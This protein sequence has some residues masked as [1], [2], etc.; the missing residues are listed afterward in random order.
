MQKK[1][2]TIIMALLLHAC[3]FAQPDDCKYDKNE[4]DKFTNQKIVWTKWERLAPL[5][6][7]EYAPD[8][9]CIIQDSIKQLIVSV[10]EYSTTYDKPT[11]GYL[12]SFIIV[13]AGSKA[14]FLMEDGK[15][16]ELK[17]AKECHSTGEY[18]PP[19]TGDNTS[20]KYAI[21]FRVVLMY[22][23]DINAIKTLSAQGVTTLRIFYKPE[24]H[25]DYTVAKKKYATLQ[26]LMNC[27]R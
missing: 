12:D 14:I 2:F 24:N 25:Q 27:I 18:K 23:L 19:H 20:D 1:S 3:L 17:T 26:N 22:G 9:R 10:S 11:Q 13:P 6:S 15:P 8:V 5:I 21:N 4:I 16:F 7:R